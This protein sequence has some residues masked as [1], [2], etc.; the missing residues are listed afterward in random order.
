MGTYNRLPVKKIPSGFKAKF[1]DITNYAD[2]MYKL[3]LI[4]KGS[5]FDILSP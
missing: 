4:S 5:E 2:R 1:G 3:K